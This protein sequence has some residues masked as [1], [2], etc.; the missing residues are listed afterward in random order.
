MSVCET[1]FELLPERFAGAMRNYYQKNIEEIRNVDTNL[2]SKRKNLVP[3][4][5]IMYDEN[6]LPKG[7]KKQVEQANLMIE[8]LK[9]MGYTPKTSTNLF[10]LE[11]MDTFE[12][13]EL[14]DYR[15]FISEKNPSAIILMHCVQAGASNIYYRSG[16]SKSYVVATSDFYNYLTSSDERLGISSKELID[17]QTTKTVYT[18]K[19]WQNDLISSVEE[20]NNMLNATTLQE[21]T[22]EGDRAIK[23]EKVDNRNGK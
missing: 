7:R 16:E 6:Y 19:T 12:D 14:K 2:E 20:I 11:I 10:D 21:Q 13:A 23:S 15:V 5:T 9:N 8:I 18:G 3:D 4:S 1:A 17:L 22:V